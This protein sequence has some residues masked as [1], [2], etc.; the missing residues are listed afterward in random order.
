MTGGA[1][2]HRGVGRAN[3]RLD[4]LIAARF[5]ACVDG[6]E[7]HVLAGMV[8]ADAGEGG[9]IQ[10]G[11]MAR[12][13]RSWLGAHPDLARQERGGRWYPRRPRLR[14]TATGG[15]RRWQWAV[16]A[17]RR[18]ASVARIACECERDPLAVATALAAAG[19]DRDWPRLRGVLPCA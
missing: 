8:S 15:P 5:A 14:T 11:R 1:R 7:P 12:R 4:A 17:Y 6:V 9:R 13:I 19:I 16:D 3:R 10:A 18:G 2:F